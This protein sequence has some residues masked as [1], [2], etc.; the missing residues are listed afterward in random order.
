MRTGARRAVPA[1][2]AASVVIAAARGIRRRRPSDTAAGPEAADA[3]TS[4]IASVR[5]QLAV[6]KAE[7]EQK[8]AARAAAAQA[9]ADSAAAASLETPASTTPPGAQQPQQQGGLRTPSYNMSA[10][11]RLHLTRLQV[12]RDMSLDDARDVL[13]RATDDYVRRLPAL[14]PVAQ[15]RNRD[16][17]ERMR[18]A[19]SGVTNASGASRGSR[20]EQRLAA[21]ESMPDDD[22]LQALRSGAVD[23]LAVWEGSA[24][25]SVLPGEMLECSRGV[26]LTAELAATLDPTVP[27]DDEARLL[28]AYR[29]GEYES[30]TEQ[31]IAALERYEKRALEGYVVQPNTVLRFVAQ[32]DPKVAEAL[33]VLDRA[34]RAALRDTAFQ[35]AVAYRRE[36]EGAEERDAVANAGAH[37]RPSAVDRA[38]F[39]NDGDFSR[40][41]AGALPPGAP[42]EVPRQRWNKSPDAAALRRKLRPQRYKT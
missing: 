14:D 7:L 22:L 38:F 30:F 37:P 42:R 5:S 36:L 35:D 40:P 41:P 23:P 16:V 11:Q 2:C 21:L 33:S 26:Q 12:R 24:E 18:V 27:T 3:A 34:R 28:E 10:L 13:R 20:T 15:Q 29:A 19:L 31:D 1:A 39:Y 25:L 9:L 4:A 32:R 8:A 6:L 17:A